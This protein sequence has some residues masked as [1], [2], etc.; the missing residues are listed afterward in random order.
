M[1]AGVVPKT[2]GRLSSG[3]YVSNSATVMAPA[4]RIWRDARQ[5]GHDRDQIRR[6]D[7]DELL[8][9]RRC[10]W[11]VARKLNRIASA[12]FSMNEQGFVRHW[13]TVPFGMWALE[14]WILAC[15]PSPFVLRKAARVFSQL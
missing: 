1:L 6:A 14:G 11:Q 12:L 10:Q 13:S 9:T 3:R 15:L 8:A 2:R 5:R 7:Q 4:S